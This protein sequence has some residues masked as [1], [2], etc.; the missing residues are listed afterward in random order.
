MTAATYAISLI[1]DRIPMSALAVRGVDLTA[2]ST[3]TDSRRRW[4]PIESVD[5]TAL[6]G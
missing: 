1:A 4:M 2:T 6:Y 3:S 5:A